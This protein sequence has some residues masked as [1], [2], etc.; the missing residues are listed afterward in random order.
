VIWFVL[1]LIPGVALAIWGWRDATE[2]RSAGDTV[3]FAAALVG[4]ILTWP[5][6]VIV[7]SRN[8]LK[9]RR[10]ARDMRHD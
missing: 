10:F 6:G 3:A 9:R 8:I 2:I 7:R 4:V 5:F 1:Y